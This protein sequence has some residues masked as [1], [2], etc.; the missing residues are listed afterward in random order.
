MNCIG[1]KQLGSSKFGHSYEA[2]TYLFGLNTF[3]HHLSANE[4]T[5]VDLLKL[6]IMG[7]FGL[8][9]DSIWDSDYEFIPKL[10]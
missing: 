8:I 9:C 4:N 7:N 5:P 6:A 1:K 3:M 2:F 10:V